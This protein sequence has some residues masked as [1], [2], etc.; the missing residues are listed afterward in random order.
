MY[1]YIG[2]INCITIASNISHTHNTVTI[3]I[4][5]IVFSTSDKI[6]YIYLNVFYTIQLFKEKIYLIKFKDSVYYSTCIDVL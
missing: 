2:N 4:Y 1:F 3:I 5:Y 6:Y